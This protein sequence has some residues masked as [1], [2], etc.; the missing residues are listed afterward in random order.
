MLTSFRP[1][2]G[3]GDVH[4]CMVDCPVYAVHCLVVMMF[5]YVWWIIQFMLTSL[6]SLFGSGD[7]HLCMVDCPVYADFTPS[8]VW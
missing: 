7:V 1:L 5:T 4:L 6:R 8:I 2:F 3:S